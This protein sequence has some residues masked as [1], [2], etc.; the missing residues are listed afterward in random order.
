MVC[1][2]ARIIGEARRISASCTSIG[3]A[4]FHSRMYSWLQ[5]RFA[6]LV[7]FHRPDCA[8]AAPHWRADGYAPWNCRCLPPRPPRPPH[9]IWSAPASGGDPTLPRVATDRVDLRTSAT[10][11]T[12]PAR[13]AT[14]LRCAVSTECRCS[15]CDDP[16]IVHRLHG[17]SAAAAQSPSR[18]YPSIRLVLPSR[19]P[20]SHFATRV[21]HHRRFVR[22]TLVLNGHVSARSEGQMTR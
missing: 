12:A 22:Q 3:P 9:P 17:S 18:R 5:I 16:A 14:A 21:A 10:A 13:P 11:L 4:P 1:S 20:V 7:I 8:D 2:R 19:S 6:T 15:P